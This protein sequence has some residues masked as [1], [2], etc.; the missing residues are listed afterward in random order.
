MKILDGLKVIDLT[1]IISGPY[2]ASLLADLGANV[3]KVEPPGGGDPARVFE[4]PEPSYSFQGMS[5]HLL[6]LARN[7]R[8][9][10]I[11]LRDPQGAAAFR[12]LVRW[13][14]VV[15]DNYR[16][17]VTGRLGIDYASLREINRK[18]IA[19][20]ITGYGLTG[21]GKDRAALDACIQAYSGVMSITG[22]PDE[23]PVRAGPLY[24]DLNSGRAGALG[25]L[26][27]VVARDRTGEGQHIDISMLD[28]QLSML[29]YTATMHLI[30][31]LPAERYGNEHG[32]HV[33]YNAYKTATGYLF[34]AVVVDNH[35]AA[36]AKALS[37]M[38]LA[39]AVKADVDYL[40]SERLLG[41]L[42]RLGEREAINQAV[43][44]VLATRS[45]DEWLADL[46]AASI[47]V[48]PVNTVEDALADDQATARRMVVDILHPAG[49]TYR[50]PGNPIKM[51]AADP[52]VFTPPPRAGEDTQSVLR[53]VLG[54]DD[55]AIDSLVRSGAVEQLE[56]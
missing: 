46:S 18:I 54:Y 20:S 28:V 51:S 6:T 13:A 37:G 45:R 43:A 32:L 1:T 29:S 22:E 30:S 26:A 7:K 2:A 24:S 42:T 38:K 11:N 50:A 49:T 53:D 8:S 16:P 44:N 33:P 25:I 31:G 52:D 3:I 35:W 9:I 27:A 36:L 14:D 10:V 19:C 5:P 39:D 12:D 55:D 17:G 23:A 4:S 48:A 47:P 15:V 40:A 56:A 41:R 21:P 34:L